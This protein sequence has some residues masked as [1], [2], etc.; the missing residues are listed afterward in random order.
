M[1]FAYSG[2]KRMDSVPKE[3]GAAFG[4]NGLKED[5]N[6][7]KLA[8]APSSSGMMI[9]FRKS[10]GTD[11]STMAAGFILFLF[12]WNFSI[13]CIVYLNRS[14]KSRLLFFRSGTQ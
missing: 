9:S 6:R 11:N 1:P 13:E 2:A 14:F 4:E 3:N 12:W 10:Q 7:Q 8:S 5:K